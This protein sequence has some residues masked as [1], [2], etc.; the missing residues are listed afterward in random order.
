MVAR[1]F[2]TWL[3]KRHLSAVALGDIAVPEA[4]GAN[5]LWLGLHSLS[6]QG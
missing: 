3:G 1:L 4:H 2:K 5:T 6:G